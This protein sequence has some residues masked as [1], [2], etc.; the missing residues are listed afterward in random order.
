MISVERKEWLPKR[1]NAALMQAELVVTRRAN[2]GAS[3]VWTKLK[4][5]YDLM[6]TKSNTYATA[7]SV[8]FVLYACIQFPK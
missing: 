5:P 8:V 1:E 7:L 4:R 3:H 2:Q 6:E